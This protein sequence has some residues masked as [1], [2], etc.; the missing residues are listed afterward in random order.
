M[1]SSDDQEAAK[2]EMTSFALFVGQNTKKGRQE[3]GHKEANADLKA[4]LFLAIS[5]S[6]DQEIA[7]IIQEIEQ[8]D[9]TT[10]E[11]EDQHI[12]HQ[13]E[14]LHIGPLESSI[15]TLLR[16]G[17]SALFSN[18]S[19]FFFFMYG[20]SMLSIPINDVQKSNRTKR[21]QTEY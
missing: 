4:G 17:F 13:S 7:G 18:Q 12:E 6:F 14:F 15:S 3:N 21:N 9:I 8:Q 10:C 5:V 16:R 11:N 20:F 1:A 19:F 2:E